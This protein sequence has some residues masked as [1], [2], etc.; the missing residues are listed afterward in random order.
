MIAYFHKSS[1]GFVLTL[2]A[3]PSSDFNAGEKIKVSGKREANA[4]CK[5]RGYRPWNF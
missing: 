2:L 3:S 4:I 1:T 5:A